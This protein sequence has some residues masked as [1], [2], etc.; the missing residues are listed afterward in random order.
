M[1]TLQQKH[2]DNLRPI[3]IPIYGNPGISEF[4]CITPICKINPNITIEVARN[5]IRAHNIAS[6]FRG[7]AN[8]IE[9]DNPNPDTDIDCYPKEKPFAHMCEIFMDIFGIQ[10][11]DL[12]PYVLLTDKEIDDA[13]RFIKNYNKPCIV[14]NPICGGSFSNDSL[15]KIK[16]LDFDKWEEIF[17]IIS[18]R[19]TILHVGLSH[20]FAPINYTIPTLD[21]NIR[22]LSALMFVCGK[23]IGVESGMTHLAVASG[24]FCHVVIPSFG[25]I[26]ADANNGSLFSNYGYIDSMWKYQPKR[27]RYYLKKDYKNIENYL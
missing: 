24:A 23:F 1:L 15:S 4:P 17:K 3:R 5:N 26:A 9:T 8:I 18:D 6:I 7:M 11:D 13:F 12:I 25:Y 20:K 19:Y 21:L 2:I 14:F 10:S 16:M 22:E 27:I